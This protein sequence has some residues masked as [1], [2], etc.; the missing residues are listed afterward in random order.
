MMLTSLADQLHEAIQE[1][2]RF[3]EAL[4]TLGVEKRDALVRVETSGV[5]EL[6]RREQ[7]VLIGLGSAGAL[8]MTLTSRL[9]DCVGLAKPSVTEISRKTGEPHATRLRSSAG[10]LRE[11]L[12]KLATI[13]K[14]NREL[15]RESMGFV[16]TFFGLLGS[17]GQEM[18]G[19]GKPG[20]TPRVVPGRL[21]IDEVV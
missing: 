9:G 10:R 5:D 16:K 4:F 17:S 14:T 13:T 20:Y 11:A 12:T 6:T 8:R 1:E 7:R 19:Y 15:T 21:M 3:A 2:I 18:N